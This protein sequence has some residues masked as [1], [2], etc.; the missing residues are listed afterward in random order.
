MITHSPS[1][2]VSALD[3]SLRSDLDRLRSEG[4]FRPLRVF[5][6]PQDA[7]AVIDGQ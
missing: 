2:A 5:S 3:A 7:E 6:S 4:L 1:A